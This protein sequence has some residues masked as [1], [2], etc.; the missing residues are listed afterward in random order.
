MD[1]PEYTHL[2]T[3]EEIACIA[4]YY[5]PRE[6]VRI[7]YNGRQVLYVVGQAVIESSCCGIGSWGYVLVPGYI[8]DWQ[9]RT[10]EAGLAVSTVEPVSDRT[11]REE[12]GKIIREAEAIPQI[13]FW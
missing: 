4:G 3:G 6:E 5:T 9:N 10:N 12:I 1:Q 11:A 13:S 2:K 7:D 8:L